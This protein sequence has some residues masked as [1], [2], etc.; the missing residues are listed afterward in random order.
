MDI[1]SILN[2]A[3]TKRDALNEH[4]EQI[5]KWRQG[6]FDKK[7]ELLMMAM[8]AFDEDVQN[9]LE[10]VKVM[11]AVQKALKKDQ[12][13]ARRRTTYSKAK[14]QDLLENDN[15]PSGIAAAWAPFYTEIAQNSSGNAVSATYN[16]GF[17]GERCWSQPCVFFVPPTQESKEQLEAV[18]PWRE[19][20][21]EIKTGAKLD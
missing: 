21:T 8:K 18:A 14:F 11:V 16:A 4:A 5:T 15:C 20:M 7:R 12:R 1:P 3:V 9:L 6:D 13:L 17:A 10:Y 19:K 2:E